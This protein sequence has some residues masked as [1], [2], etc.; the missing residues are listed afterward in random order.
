[1]HELVLWSGQ[2]QRQFLWEWRGGLIVVGTVL[3]RDGGDVIV[4]IC[5]EL[6]LGGGGFTI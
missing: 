1:M 5:P 6:R 4:D 2:R 3:F